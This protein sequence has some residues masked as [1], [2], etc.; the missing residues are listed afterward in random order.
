MTSHSDRPADRRGDRPHRQGRERVQP[1]QLRRE[2]VGPGR[3]KPPTSRRRSFSRRRIV[4]SYVAEKTHP[5]RGAR[6]R[7]HRCAGSS[8]SVVAGLSA[9][10]SGNAVSM[11]NRGQRYLSRYYLP[12]YSPMTPRQ[13]I[14]TPQSK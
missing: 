14:C 8:G 5:V 10:F 7:F 6:E 11:M 3:A 13:I 9:R 2:G 1:V 12:I 4:L